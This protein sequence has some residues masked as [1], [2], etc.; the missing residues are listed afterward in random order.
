MAPGGYRA[1]WQDWTTQVKPG[2][3]AVEG[4]QSMPRLP[5]SAQRPEASQ[6]PHCPQEE[7][8][9]T[10][11]FDSGLQQPFRQRIPGQHAWPGSPQASQVGG[12]TALMQTESKQVVCAQQGWPASPQGTQVTVL[13]S[14]AVRGA[15]QY[16]VPVVV[17]QQPCLSPPHCVLLPWTQDCGWQESPLL[18]E[19]HVAVESQA[20]P[21]ATH[22]RAVPQQ[23]PAAQPLPGQ[24]GR[25]G[26]PHGT[27]CPVTGSHTVVGSRH[28]SPAQQRSPARPQG[29][30]VPAEQ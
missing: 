17:V 10:H 6:F 21:S 13:E 19:Q 8:R 16:A 5:Q 30:Q 2:R 25:P 7:S 26:L 22:R 18:P 20:I 4:Q 12:L 9:S 15:E 23:W 11:R 27:H 14:H 1:Y 28:A 29:R 3:Q 24:Q